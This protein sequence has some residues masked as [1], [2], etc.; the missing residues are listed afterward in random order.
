MKEVRH[1]QVKRIP[2]RVIGFLYI[3]TLYLRSEARWLLDRSGYFLLAGSAFILVLEVVLEIWGK[4]LAFHPANWVRLIFWVGATFVAYTKIREWREHEQG[5]AFVEG[6][7]RVVDTLAVGTTAFDTTKAIQSILEA[8]V[9]SFPKRGDIRASLA[10]LRE[11]GCQEIAMVTSEADEPLKGAVFKPDE[12][13]IGVS[14]RER[15]I[16]YV[17][18]VGFGHAILQGL[19]DPDSWM[20]R[21]D[22]FSPRESDSFKSLLTVP[23]VAEDSCFGTLSLVSERANAFLRLDRLEAYFFGFS[24]AQALRRGNVGPLSVK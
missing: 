14:Y 6:V 13:C 4:G 24:V 5:F 20:L 23:L 8:T 18:R 1:E 3:W 22:A 10:L 19:D 7:R 16:A 17:P 9:A 21:A 12:G 2:S 11:D 15:V